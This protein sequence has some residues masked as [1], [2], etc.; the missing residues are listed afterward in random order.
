[1]VQHTARQHDTVLQEGML[2]QLLDRSPLPRISLEAPA[3]DVKQQPFDWLCVSLKPMA[4]RVLH[5]HGSILKSQHSLHR[6]QMPERRS[7]IHHLVQDDPHGPYIRRSPKF[8]TAL[9]HS[10][11]GHIADGAH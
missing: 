3:K 11:W 5:A 10:F 2:Q 4:W 9:L 8:Y 6:V 7:T 1:M